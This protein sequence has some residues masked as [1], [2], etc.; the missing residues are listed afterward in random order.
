MEVGE[1][2]L[3]GDGNPGAR[4]LEE[5]NTFVK[6]MWGEGLDRY[7]GVAA[8]G[9]KRVVNGRWAAEAGHVD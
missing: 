4:G 5:G 1:S 8:L 7:A 2:A 9:E 3:W 6:G